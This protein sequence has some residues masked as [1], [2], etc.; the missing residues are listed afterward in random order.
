MD[1]LI[2]C[3]G[4]LSLPV[5]HQ[6]AW[7]FLFL[8]SRGLPRSVNRIAHYALTAAAIDK[9]RT[10]SCEHMQAGCQECSQ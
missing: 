7:L 4:R 1:W 9:S 10:V 5:L 2:L 6:L 3:S 8:A